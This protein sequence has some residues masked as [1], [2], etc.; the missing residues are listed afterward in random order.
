MVHHQCDNKNRTEL[1]GAI[2]AGRYIG[3][4]LVIFFENLSVKVSDYGFYQQE[5]ALPIQ[6]AIRDSGVPRNFVRDGVQQIQLRTEDRENGDL[7][8]VVL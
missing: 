5:G 6:W 8:E 4:I 3:Q 1:L 2:N 7:G